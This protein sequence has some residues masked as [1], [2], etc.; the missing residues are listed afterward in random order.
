MLSGLYS[1]WFLY[2]R[3]HIYNELR[4][5]SQLVSIYV[6][7]FTLLE[8]CYKDYIHL[9][10]LFTSSHLQRIAPLQST[11]FYIHVYKQVYLTGIMLSGLYQFGF[12]I[13]VYT[14]TANCI[15][16]VNWF[17][18]MLASLP[19]WNYVIRIVSIWFLYLCVHIYS[20]L[21]LC[22]QLVSI[23]VSKFALLELCYQDCINLVS[24][25]T[26]KHLQ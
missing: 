11:R 21:Q 7:K 9:I 1:I 16:V 24:L 13:Y 26:C 25:F 3:V 5:C 6:S 19:Y 18:S 12:F 4:L 23:Y 20:E 15:F 17:Q 22:S 2:L 8:L 10:S 14:F